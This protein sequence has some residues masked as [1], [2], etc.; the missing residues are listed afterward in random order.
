M[1][2]ERQNK[3]QEGFSL[4]EL[5][6]VVAI[7]G[8]LAAIGVPQYSKSQAKARQSEAKASLANLFTAEQSFMAEYNQYSVSLKLVGFAVSGQSLR[9]VT[10]FTAGTGCTGYSTGANAPTELTSVNDTWSDGTNVNVGNGYDAATFAFAPSARTLTGTSSSCTATM[11]SQAF[12]GMAIG[13]PNANVGT[14]PYDG[15]TITNTKLV[16]NSTPGIK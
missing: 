1:C 4:L 13:D 15:W 2:F 11:G 10:G 14:T 9:Y 12:V 3:N 7:I 16:S 8:V 5:M 6:V